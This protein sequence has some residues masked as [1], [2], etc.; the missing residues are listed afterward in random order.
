MRSNRRRCRWPRC[1]GRGAARPSLVSIVAGVWS[2]GVWSLAVVV[3]LFP[4]VFPA[5]KL[6]V[7]HSAAYGPHRAALVARGGLLSKWSMMDVLV[8]ALAVFAAKTSGLASAAALPG[9]WFYAGAALLSA[10]AAARIR[11]RAAV[12]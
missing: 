11:K 12:G 1:L 3:W 2:D 6:A 5:L 4:V 10:I 7:L 8:V 9:L